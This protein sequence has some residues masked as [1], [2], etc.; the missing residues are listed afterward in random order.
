MPTSEAATVECLACGVEVP[1]DRAV[2]LETP[3]GPF[4]VCQACHPDHRIARR[5]TMEGGNG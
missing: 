4:T 1:L 5:A 3:Y 2:D